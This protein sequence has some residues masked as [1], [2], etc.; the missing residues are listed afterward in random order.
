[1]ETAILTGIGVAALGYVARTIWR[2]INGKEVCNCSSAGSCANCH[3][4]SAKLP[5]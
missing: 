2:G 3:C 1:M 5:K 4:P